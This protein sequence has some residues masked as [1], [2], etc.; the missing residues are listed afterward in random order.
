MSTYVALHVAIC[1]A[2]HC[3]PGSDWSQRAANSSADSGVA[4][5]AASVN[6]SAPAATGVQSQERVLCDAVVS[7][8][9]TMKAGALATG[10]ISFADTASA[11][12]N[13]E[14]ALALGFDFDEASAKDVEGVV[15]DN[16][17]PLLAVTA[18]GV[19]VPFVVDVS[20]FILRMR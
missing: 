19:I 7:E 4:S 15:L 5:A 10:I 14:D 1:F 8:D 12:L 16:A 13:P 18:A 20:A 9:G 11:S 3:C 6:E 2:L 17:I